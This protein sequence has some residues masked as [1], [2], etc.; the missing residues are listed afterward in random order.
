MKQSVPVLMYHSIGMPNKKWHW[1][2][3]TCPYQIFEKQLKWL[4][5]NE[6][7]TIHLNELYEY[8]FNHGKIPKRSI[9]L[10]FDDGY[11]DN[12]IFAYPLLKK[13]DYKGT[14][15]VNPEFVD[16]RNIKRLRLDQTDNIEKLEKLGFLSWQEIQEMEIDGSIDIQSHAMT[17]THYPISDKIIDFRNPR[18][19]YI[20]LTWNSNVK[21]KPNLQVDN[22]KLKKLGEPVY[23]MN[24]S[25]R[26][27]RF[28]PD[29]NLRY[30]LVEYV[31]KNGSTKFFNNPTWKKELIEQA[32]KYKKNNI[33]TERFEN[34]KELKE[35]IYQEL[36][37]SK[38]IL[39]E[40]LN[41]KIEFL[42]WPE[43]SA[44]EIGCK[45]AREIGYKMTTAAKDIPRLRK[46]IP[47]SPILK[48]D[49][50][51]RFSPVLNWNG[52]EGF[53]AKIIYM[54]GFWLG[55]LILCFRNIFFSKYWA[56]ALILLKRIFMAH[57]K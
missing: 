33:L 53:N 52:I 10:T 29:R 1:N 46:N 38:E 13:Y 24:T 44:S 31:K 32:E 34:K 39:S 48:I 40:N 50:I 57:S 18:D 11:A 21:E 49:R 28:F 27:K 7:H 8:I 4:K 16:Q 20:W 22:Y 17:H 15:F 54:N 47:N 36:K 41:K 42:C 3:L 45:I 5:K 37:Q 30:T 19:S 25:L 6:F 14:V 51:R 2:Y 35:R 56:K 12:W 9:V 43:G 23:E 55:V 26:Y